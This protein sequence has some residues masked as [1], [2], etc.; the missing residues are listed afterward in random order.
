MNLLFRLCL[1]S[2]TIAGCFFSFA[3][4]SNTT[5]VNPNQDQKVTE[6]FGSCTVGYTTD[7]NSVAGTYVACDSEEDTFALVGQKDGTWTVLLSPTVDTDR[8]DEESN[9]FVTVD[10]SIKVDDNDAHTLSMHV[11]N[12]NVILDYSLEVSQLTPILAELAVGREIVIT[13]K[14]KETVF[15]IENAN[16]AFKY[17]FLSQSVSVNEVAQ[18]LSG[19]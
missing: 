11:T 7:R 17:L 4:D 12:W 3:Q 10:V 13:R 15:D 19:E 18:L 1:A 5:E 2:T 8:S 9:A 6:R 14:G 16:Q